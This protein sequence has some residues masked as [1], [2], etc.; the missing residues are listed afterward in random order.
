MIGAGIAAVTGWRPGAKG[1]V[2]L[3]VCLATVAALVVKDRLKIL[4]G[5]TWLET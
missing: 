4:F 1:R 5:R 3:A 2:L